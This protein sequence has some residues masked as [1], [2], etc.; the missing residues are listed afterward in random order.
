MNKKFKG[1]IAANVTPFT[2]DGS[3]DVEALRSELNYLLDKGV[4]G[5]FVGGT[6][7]EGPMMSPE[8]YGA[9]IQTVTKTVNGR[10]G[11]I[12]QIGATSLNQA[13][14]Q[15]KYAEEAGVDA[16]AAIPPFFPHDDVAVYEYYR[17][18][19]ANTHLPLYIYNNP[20]RS[21]CKI[22][23][24]LLGKI[25]KIDG[26]AGMKDSCDSIT[27]FTKYKAAAGPDFNLLI[28]ND[29]FTLSALT[30][31]ADGGVIVLAGVFPEIY[32]DM[33]KA[34]HNGDLETARALQNRAIEI[35]QVLKGGPYISTYKAVLNMLGR[36]A[37]YSKKPIRCLTAEEEAKIRKGLTDLGI[38]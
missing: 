17:D 11:I 33:Y 28:G 26:I 20:A 18:L 8:E 13:L 24:A 3:L 35:R 23:P 14:Q 27:E 1:I 10:V 31:G 37:G 36:K 16:L 6:Y 7:G 34:F 15:A 22:S 5:F 29:D 12:A 4:N 21:G 19:C 25:A 9:Y 30:M 38:L 32:L 2:E